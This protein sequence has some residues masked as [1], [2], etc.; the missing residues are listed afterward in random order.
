MSDPNSRSLINCLGVIG[1]QM[2]GAEIENK[3]Y[4]RFY[5]SLT[6]FL[7][8]PI[9]DQRL[10]LKTGESLVEFIFERQSDST[11]GK[12]ICL[13]WLEDEYEEWESLVSF[14]DQ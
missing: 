5:A 10:F 9:T 7:F 11:N 1:G 14:T 3:V 12:W 8:D 4:E 6:L 2:A 13:G